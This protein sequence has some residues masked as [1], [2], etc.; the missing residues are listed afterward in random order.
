MAATTQSFRENTRAYCP[1]CARH[2]FLSIAPVPPLPEG[3]VGPE[4]MYSGIC[5]CGAGVTLAITSKAC[6]VTHA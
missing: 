3:M 6:Q 5:N 4:A 1:K 2:V